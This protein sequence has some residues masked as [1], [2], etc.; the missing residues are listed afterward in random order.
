MRSNIKNDLDF[1]QAMKLLEEE[2]RALPVV[3]SPG[4]LTQFRS[5]LELLVHWNQRLNLTGLKSLSEI[6]RKLFL[7]SLTPVPFL[8]E[9][10]AIMDLGSGAGFPGLPIKI[11]QPAQRMILMESSSKKVSFL[12]EVVRRLNFDQVL[13]FQTY[14]GK[15]SPPFFPPYPLD[16]IVTRAVGKTEELV[17]IA[18]ACLPP[19]GRLVLMKGKQW[20]K[21]MI[22]ATPMIRKNGFRVEKTIGINVPESEPERVL[23]F[24]FKEN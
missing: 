22:T 14:L 8:P 23:L 2:A 17:R 6:I 15:G 4:Q 10:V 12:K 21:E 7:D 9:G 19:G 11:A 20:R 13:I 16:F 3:L 24:L 5:Y 18:T 1:P